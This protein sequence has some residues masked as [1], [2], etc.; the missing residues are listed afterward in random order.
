MLQ[1][2]TGAIWWGWSKVP[3]SKAPQCSPSLPASHS[4]GTQ[5]NRWMRQARAEASQKRGPNLT[6]RNPYINACAHTSH[7]HITCTHHTHTSHKTQNPYINASTHTL[8]I[9]HT[10]ITHTHHTQNPIYKSMHTHITHTY[11]MCITHAHITHTSHAH[12][13]HIT[14]TSHTHTSHTYHTHI[15]Q[16]PIYKSRHITHTSHT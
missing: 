15:T 1:R 9:H 4:R 5:S 12:H 8:H 11:H 10:H 14:H 7:A 6:H 16:N 2:P 3:M 13:T